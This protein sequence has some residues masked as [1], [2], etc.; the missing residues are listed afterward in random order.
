MIMPIF[1]YNNGLLLENTEIEKQP[2]LIKCDPDI[3]NKIMLYNKSNE[4]QITYDID[5][6]P[7]AL[8]SS[9]KQYQEVTNYLITYHK[10]IKIK[11]SKEYCDDKGLYVC[12]KLKGTLQNIISA[13]KYLNRLL[14]K[15]GFTNFVP[16]I[17][18][19]YKG[20]HDGIHLFFDHSNIMIGT[21]DIYLYYVNLLNKILFNRIKKCETIYITGSQLT[22]EQIAFSL[23]RGYHVEYCIAFGNEPEFYVD[24]RIHREMEILFNKHFSNPLRQPQTLILLSGDGNNNDYDENTNFYQYV[25]YALYIGW[26]VEIWA[27]KDRISAKYFKLNQKYNKTLKIYDLYAI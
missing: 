16:Q 1:V 4:H 23:K 18:Y 20:N 5:I 13:K 27:W 14:L 2:K 10:I 3:N 26:N 15:N 6:I 17:K 21:G 12:I 8:I 7:V 22:T 24:E 25:E 11:I 19:E 9:D